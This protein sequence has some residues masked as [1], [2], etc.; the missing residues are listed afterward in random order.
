MGAVQD[1][2]S[3]QSAYNKKL[4]EA[5]F[6]R[7]KKLIQLEA[8]KTKNENENEREKLALQKKQA[9]AEF[10][11]TK[12]ALLLGFQT[13]IRKIEAELI[14]TR[15]VSQ[16][17]LFEKFV[18]FM[19]KTLNTNDALITQQTK[20]P[21]SLEFQT[22]IRK[23]EAEFIKMNMVMQSSIFETFMNFMQQALNLNNAWVR[24]QTKLY[25]LAINPTLTEK[26]AS[27]LLN[28]V[29]IAIKTKPINN[30]KQ[31]KQLLNLLQSFKKRFQLTINEDVMNMLTMK[32]KLSSITTTQN[33]ETNNK[34]KK[35]KT[36]PT[37][38][39]NG[40][41]QVSIVDCRQIPF[42]GINVKT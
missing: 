39:S 41:N 15:M 4:N 7:Q 12:A 9:E 28:A 34:P 17:S 6:E 8:E 42:K 23:A 3:S 26:Q 11:L 27:K 18:D 35:L 1:K 31:R 20:F 14:K 13:A 36:N 24:Q 25:E 5:E 33:N 22:Y 10:Q 16:S 19:R 37:N 21:S 32:R 2:L 30:D 29:S 40:D 38:V